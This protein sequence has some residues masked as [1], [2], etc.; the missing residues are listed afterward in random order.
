MQIINKNDILNDNQYTIVTIGKFDG[1]HLGH[2]KI[3]N[4]VMKEKKEDYI[5]LVASFVDNPRVLVEKNNDG[6]LLEENEK[7]TLLEKVGFDIYCGLPFDEEMM[8]TSAEAFFIK[9]IVNKW[10]AK[11]LVIGDDFCFGKNRVGTISFL[12]T[13]CEKENIKLVV[14]DRLLYEGEPVSSSRIKL[15]LKNG[16]IEDANNMLGYNYN[17]TGI[18]REGR[19]L[20]RTIGFPTVNI[21][22]ETKRCIP[23]QGVYGCEVLISGNK[24][25][26]ITNIG[27]NP[28]VTTEHK[29][30]IETFIYDYEGD[31]YGEVISV[32]LHTFIRAEKKFNSIDELKKQI[33]SDK[34]CWTN[35]K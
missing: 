17:F 4:Q 3:F 2:M 5:T 29:V 7:I 24:F 10:H 27:I 23:L 22:P 9:N 8:N 18:V 30:G 15:C 11:I 19:R 14:V 21:V 25:M 6:I 20:G 28:T 32:Y 35:N 16:H 13:M 12:K 1:V 26:G 33:N 31:L 34:K